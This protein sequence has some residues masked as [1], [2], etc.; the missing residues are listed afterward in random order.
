MATLTPTGLQDLVFNALDLR[1]RA[2]YEQVK[3]FMEPVAMQVPSS[4]DTNV[5]G[6]MD[7]VPILR[8]WLGSRVVD[9]MVA[10]EYRL[11][12]KLFEKTLGIK[13]TV[14]QDQQ[15]QLYGPWAEEL[16]QQA[17]RWPD[18]ELTTA[19]ENGTSAALATTFDGV[20][21]F[22]ASHPIDP[23]GQ[24][25]GTQSNNF[26]GGGTVLSATSY[27]T[28]LAAGRNFKGRDNKPLGTFMNTQANYLIVPPALEKTAREILNGEFISVTGGSTQTNVWMNSAQLIVNPLLTSATAWYLV[29]ASRAVKPLLW[30]LRDAPEF[31]QK[32]A[33]D[34]D[35]V[36]KNDE[37]LMGVRAR[38]AAGYGLWFLAIRNAGA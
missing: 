21:Y 22:S 26:T 17:R 4:S 2:G 5:Y 11:Q 33:P 3:S 31:V 19:L 23:K 30:Q 37:Y 10:N 6:W 38:G 32:T 27:S 35:H 25:A 12:N 24:V 15:A 36:F 29:D 7:K 18:Y 8:E 9:D 20:A 16:G 34:D 14:L 1:Y 13:R 28:A